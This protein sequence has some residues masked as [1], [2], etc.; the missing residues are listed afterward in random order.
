MDAKSILDQLLQSGRGI[1]AQGQDMAE[2]K[3]GVPEQG[4]ER[5][6]MLSGMGKGALAAGALALLL[7]TKGGRRLGG[8]ALKLGSL[9]AVGG[10]AYKAYQNWQSGQSGQTADPG[11]AIDQLAAPE[12]ASRSEKLL[13]A[14]IA[15]A[16]ADGHIDENEMSNLREQ[17]G[18]LGLESSAVEFFREEVRKP[19]D[20]RV[21]AA[22]ADSPEIAAEIYL[23]SRLMI[24][25]GNAMERA[26]LEELV[27]ELKLDPDLVRQLETAVA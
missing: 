25:T 7:G 10:V 16:K 14:M 12:A 1:A 5:E 11:P 21:V 4:T 8:T 20:A 18:K 24:D 15:A 23:A 26:Y 3:L 13:R 9:A 6:A 27:H 22:D 19:L 2:E 17:I